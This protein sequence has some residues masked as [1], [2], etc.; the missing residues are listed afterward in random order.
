[1]KY[2]TKTRNTCTGQVGGIRFFYHE[3]ISPILA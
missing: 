1:M 2:I 3:I